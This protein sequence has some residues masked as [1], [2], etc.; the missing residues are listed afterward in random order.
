M[1]S[2]YQ[3]LQS[4]NAHTSYLRGFAMKLARDKN[5]ADDLF[6]ETALSAFRHQN[7]FQKNTNMKAWLST[8]MKNSFINLY[9]KNQRRNELQSLNGDS[10]F[11]NNQVGVTSNEGEMNLNIDEI[12]RMID[13]LAEGYRVP[14]LLAYQGYQYEEIQHKMGNL[15]MGTIKSRIH[16]ARKILK[17]QITAM[18]NS[19]IA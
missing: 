12:T 9:R 16:H 5:V 19:A 1:S 3:F 13:H 10:Y 17:T 7:K 14:F 2:N 18:H 6:Q 8:I 11:L 15:P 4:F